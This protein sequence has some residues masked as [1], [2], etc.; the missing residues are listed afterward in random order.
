MRRTACFQSLPPTR[1]TPTPLEQE[2]GSRQLF[3]RAGGVQLLPALVKA[4]NTPTNSQLLYELCMCAWQMT[5]LEPAAEAMAKAGIVKALVQVR[6]AAAAALLWARVGRGRLGQVQG[7][8][9]LCEKGG[10]LISQRE[11]CCQICPSSVP[12]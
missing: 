8:E 4:S 5:F 3:S 6:A 7:R 9:R 10:E 2:R 1:H 11:V 12:S